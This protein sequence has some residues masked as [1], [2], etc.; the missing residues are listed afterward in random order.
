MNVSE[1]TSD[2]KAAV[3][4]AKYFVYGLTNVPSLYS[5][6]GKNGCVARQ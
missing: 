6:A 3:S 1:L 5:L 2:P 4:H